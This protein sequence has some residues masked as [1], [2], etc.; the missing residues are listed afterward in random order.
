MRSDTLLLRDIVDAIETI[1]Q[2]L[3]SDQAAFDGDPPMQSHILRHVMIVGEISWRLSQA[4][5][6]RNPQIPWKQIAGMRHILVHDY[7]RVVWGGG[8]YDSHE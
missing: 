5:K 8:V 3:P 4:L 2:Y 6:A 1:R 7:F